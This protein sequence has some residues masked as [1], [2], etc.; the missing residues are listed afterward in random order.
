MIRS[1]ILEFN[2]GPSGSGES[3]TSYLALTSTGLSGDEKSNGLAFWSAYLV[4]G[5]A[6]LG[7]LAKGGWCYPSSSEPSTIPE[8]FSEIVEDG[9]SEV[10]REETDKDNDKDKDKKKDK[11]NCALTPDTR[12]PRPRLPPVSDKFKVEL[13]SYW[14]GISST[15]LNVAIT[16]YCLLAKRG[17]SQKSSPEPSTTIHDIW[18]LLDYGDGNG[19]DNDKGFCAPVSSSKLV[20]GILINPE[21]S[22]ERLFEG[23]A[24]ANSYTPYVVLEFPENDSDVQSDVPFVEDASAPVDFAALFD[25]L[26]DAL[27]SFSEVCTTTERSPLDLARLV[28]FGMAMFLCVCLRV[29]VFLSTGRFGRRGIRQLVEQFENAKASVS[30][31]SLLD[32]G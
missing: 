21:Q 25:A 24:L 9:D 18:E 29:M 19:N 5:I 28:F 27:C 13:D 23:N 8:S 1:R 31:S 6:I 2:P 30:H 3:R 20:L 26:R 16:V 15:S 7:V 11:E 10:S 17:R 22:I 14:A 12:A 32:Y 4:V